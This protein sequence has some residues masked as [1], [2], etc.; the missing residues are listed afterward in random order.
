MY[1]QPTNLW[2]ESYYPTRVRS[3]VLLRNCGLKSKSHYRGIYGPGRKKKVHP[4]DHSLFTSCILR[5]VSTCSRSPWLST[6][7]SPPTVRTTST[8]SV[9]PVVSDVRVLPSTSSLRATS[10]TCAILSSSTTPRSLKCPWTL[11]TLSKWWL[12]REEKK[13]TKQSR[14]CASSVLLDKHDFTSICIGCQPKQHSSPCAFWFC[15]DRFATAHKKCIR[16]CFTPTKHGT[17]V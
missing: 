13:R 8:A 9:V 7:T 16:G 10:A 6:S 17:C 2:H 14:C 4:R 1:V 3:L 15:I 5:M 11:P 12:E